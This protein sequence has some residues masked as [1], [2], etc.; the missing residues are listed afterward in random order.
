MKEDAHKN[1]FTIIE[2]SLVIAIAGLIFLMIFVALPA[3]R[4]QARDTQRRE[5]VMSFLSSVKKFQTNNRGVL[6]TGEGT[7]GK[8]YAGG[9]KSWQGFY[10][11]YL[12]DSFKDPDGTN[13]YL[14]VSSCKTGTGGSTI[15]ENQIKSDNAT[16]GSRNRYTLTVITGAI[17]KGEQAE[18]SSNPRRLAVLYRLEGAGTYCNNT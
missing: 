5:D 16:P 12:G 17:C 3:L 2:V 7:F 10:N 6:P 8:G 15:C 13:Y 18:P 11:K 4:R 1:G 14:D 9:D